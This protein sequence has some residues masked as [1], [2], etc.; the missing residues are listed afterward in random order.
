MS[1]GKFNLLF[2]F[3]FMYFQ[4]VELRIEVFME[5]NSKQFACICIVRAIVKMHQH[6]N[7]R[8]LKIR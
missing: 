5:A 2:V 8:Q 3:I 4:N 7:N 6:T 1:F